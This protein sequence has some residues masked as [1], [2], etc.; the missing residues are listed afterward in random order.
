[1][2]FHHIGY[3]VKSISKTAKVY[4]LGGCRSSQV[5][6]DPVQNVNICWIFGGGTQIELLEPVDG[7]SPVN[8]ILE[9]NGVAP[10]HVCYMVEDIEEAILK[11]KK[12]KYI[13]V[14]SPVEAPAITNSRV[15]FLFNRDIGLVELVEAPGKITF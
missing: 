2:K 12:M 15:A 4:E 9:K 13:V 7:Q 11:L 5:V 6:Y 14:V 3:A 10:Y 1:M 8:K